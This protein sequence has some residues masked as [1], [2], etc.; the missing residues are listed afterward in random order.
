MMVKTQ[1][2]IRPVELLRPSEPEPVREPEREVEHGP[3]PAARAAPAAD[4]WGS[5]RCLFCP[6][7]WGTAPGATIKFIPKSSRQRNKRATSCRQF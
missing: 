7:L 1:N 6:A 3:P 4:C 2:D 5:A